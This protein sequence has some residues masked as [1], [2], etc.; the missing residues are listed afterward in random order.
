MEQRI[1]ETAERLFLEKGYAMT[2]TTEIAKNVG[3]NQAL[4][5]YYYRKK[6]FLYQK[7]FEQKVNLFV[8]SFTKLDEKGDTF[9]EKFRQRMEMHFDMLW[10]NKQLPSLLLNELYTNPSQM[11]F[12]K[13]IV[14]DMDKSVFVNFDKELQ[15]EIKAGRI[16][17]TNMVDVILN[18]LSLNLSVFITLPMLK[19]AGVVT[20]ENEDEFIAHRK[21]VVIQTL[22]N[23]LLK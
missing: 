17:D 20:D 23:S 22:I 19:Q 3:C 11:G 4:V 9:I 12:V 10:E 21:E 15:Q 13:K 6:E 14:A 1:L 5:H 2:S 8:A 7:I 16:K 18:I